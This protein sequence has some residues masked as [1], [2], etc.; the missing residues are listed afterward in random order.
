M[1]SQLIGP[2]IGAT[3]AL[4]LGISLSAMCSAIA[5]VAGRRISPRTV[6]ILGEWIGVAIYALACLTALSGGT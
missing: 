5:L 3:L 1:S 2:L 6:V 4:A